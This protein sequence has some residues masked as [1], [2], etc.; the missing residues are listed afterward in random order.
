M[1]PRRKR[2]TACGLFRQYRLE[3]RLQRA[4]VSKCRSGPAE[5]HKAK[6][7]ATVRRRG[8]CR[9]MNRV[10]ASSR[11]L[12]RDAGSSPFRH[13]NPLK[14]NPTVEEQVPRDASHAAEQR[15]F[16]LPGPNA[17]SPHQGGGKATSETARVCLVSPRRLRVCA[18]WGLACRRSSLPLPTKRLTVTL[19]SAGEATCQCMLALHLA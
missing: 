4:T 5:G 2:N 6:N 12:F 17:P 8:F 15:P 18:A 3:C 14:K 13:Q 9:R 1:A 16:L 11:V 10:V 7:T 19:L